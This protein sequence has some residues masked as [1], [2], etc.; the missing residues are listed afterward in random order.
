MRVAFALLA[1]LVFAVAGT[2][3]AETVEIYSAGSL[4]EVVT[5]LI[6]EGAP[7]GVEV[8]PTF[9][10][11]GALRERIEKGE[12]PDLFLSADLGS[13]QKLAEAGRTIV[14]V[15]AFARNRMCLLTRR[16]VGVTPANLVDRMLAKDTKLRTSTPIADPAGD[17]AMTIFDKIDAAHPG[18]GNTLRGKAQELAAVTPSTPPAPGKSPL[19]A[20]FAENKID[21]MI[22]YCSGVETLQ[23]DV[24]D[25]VGVPFPADLDPH[26]VYGMAVLSAKPEALR[27]ALFLLSSAGQDI[28]HKAGLVPLQE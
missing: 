10:G 28:V 22:A 1:I 4:R 21:M 17:Y 15:V 6:K 9:G 14:P 19:A 12:A 11:S 2:S 8:K 13:P 26:P 16:P 5:Q 27:L 7:K 25:L 20:L 23:Q 18:A 24:P 3:R